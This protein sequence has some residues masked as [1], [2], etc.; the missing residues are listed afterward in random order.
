MDQPSHLRAIE[1]MQ[2]DTARALSDALTA[3]VKPRFP[4]MVSAEVQASRPFALYGVALLADSVSTV[5]GIAHLSEREREADTHSL[6]RDLIEAVITF[7]W[8]AIDP[9]PHIQAWLLSDK[10]ERVKV[11]NALHTFGEQVLDPSFRAALDSDIAAGGPVLIDVA[12]RAK[13]ADKFW[14]PRVA[15]LERVV[16]GGRVF[17]LLYEL[18]YRYTSSFTHSAPMT[19]NKLIEPVQDGAVVVLEGTT[20]PQRALTFA[21]SAFGVMLYVASETLGWPAVHEIDAVFD[22]ALQNG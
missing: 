2:P 20:G 22:K 10:K 11:D 7:A 5:E 21:P 15:R 4:Y 3:L 1:S 8:L 16:E 14:T 9:G 12:S 13:S 17:E 18:T 6:L 19:V